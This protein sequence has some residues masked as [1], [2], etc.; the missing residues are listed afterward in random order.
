MVAQQ[1]SEVATCPNASSDRHR[2]G[3]DELIN[4]KKTAE[5]D[6]LIE[7]CTAN[8]QACPGDERPLMI[9][10]SSYMKKGAA[11]AQTASHLL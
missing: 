7:I 11:H 6:R 10:A 5:F 1:V 3:P 4:L 2:N 8:I 9:R